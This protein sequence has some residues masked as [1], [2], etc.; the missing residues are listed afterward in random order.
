MAHD[1]RDFDT[2]TR[3][4]RFLGRADLGTALA[5]LMVAGVVLWAVVALGRDVARHVAAMEA[6]VA[7]QGALGPI[8]FGLLFVAVTSL[9]F[10]ESVLSMAAGALFGL[11]EGFVV[12]LV[13]SLVAAVL[14][15]QVARRL[16][17]APIERWVE[18]RPSL[19]VLQR[20][21]L[22]DE[23]RLQALLRLTP[24]NPAS[25]SYL[26]G[27]AGVRLGGF[28]MTCLA[29]VP[30]LFVE[31]YFGYAGKHVAG[32]AGSMGHGVLVHDIV[33]GLGLAVS[34]LVVVRI[35]RMARRA[36]EEAVEREEVGRSGD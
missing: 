31:T 18:G 34:I 14:Q 11:T 1:R 30:M 25:V 2:R 36:V 8:L 32:M 5:Y 13:A 35:S 12:V 24:L 21:V 20:A 17:E 23:V 3:L 4:R 16:L 10:P 22:H 27:A 15:H 26:M 9:L 7:A 19:D 6:W 28:V 33:G 29:F